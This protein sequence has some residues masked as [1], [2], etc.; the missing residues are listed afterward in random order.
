MF[1]SPIKVTGGSYIT[2]N[3]YYT[4]DLIVSVP[5]RGNW[6][7][8]Q[9]VLVAFINGLCLVSV[10]SR[11]DWGVLQIKGE[12]KMRQ[13]IGV[14]SPPKVTGVSYS[15]MNEKASHDVWFPSPPEVT[16]VSYIMFRRIFREIGLFPPPSEANGGSYRTHV[17]F[18]IL[19]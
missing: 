4:S 17:L 13:F 5:F 19:C 10:P 6:G 1:P 3:A 12:I 2:Q 7:F 18:G 14:P 16:E 9:E 15:A 8:L 11:G